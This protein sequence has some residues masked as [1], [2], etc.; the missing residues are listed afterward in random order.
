MRGR[1]HDP[2]VPARRGPRHRYGLPLH[3]LARRPVGLRGLPRNPIWKHA[4]QNPDPLIH[5]RSH[6]WPYSNPNPM[7]G[8]RSFFCLKNV[9]FAVPTSI[10]NWNNPNPTPTPTP[11]QPPNPNQPRPQ[12]PFIPLPGPNFKIVTYTPLEGNLMKKQET[13][14]CQ[15]I[16]RCAE[17]SRR[18]G[19]PNSRGLTKGCPKRFVLPLVQRQGAFLDLF[20]LHSL[21]V[22]HCASTFLRLVGIGAL[23]GE[24]VT[25]IPRPSLTGGVGSDTPSTCQ[26][27]C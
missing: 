19:H 21:R 7:P 18:G 6:T 3:R 15:K 10:F 2:P 11:I 27:V 24:G 1:L 23:R 14:T 16:T 5:S 8:G 17:K 26:A 12:T 9:Q 4:P 25:P 13:K 22:R 20:Q